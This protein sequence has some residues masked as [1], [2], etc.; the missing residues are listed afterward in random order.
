L[1]QEQ[2]GA[3][4]GEVVELICHLD[5]MSPED[6]PLVIERLMAA[7]ALDAAAAPLYMKKGRP[8]LMLVVVTAPEQAEVLAELILEQTTTLGLRLRHSQRRMLTRDQ[9]ILDSPWGPV[10]VKRAQT[11]AGA[12]LHPEADEVARIAR[13]TGLP[14]HIVRQRVLQSTESD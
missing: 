8:G 13:Q 6:L 7:G 2:E 11:P 14:P 12:R 5:D 10:K 4:H 9:I 3:S 1:G